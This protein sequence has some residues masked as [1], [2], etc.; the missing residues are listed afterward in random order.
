MQFTLDA[1]VDY[2]NLQ[3][4]LHKEKLVILF[5]ANLMHF[6]LREVL[7]TQVFMVIKKSNLEN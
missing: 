2:R 4:N 1:K 6:N 3:D 7:F 5:V